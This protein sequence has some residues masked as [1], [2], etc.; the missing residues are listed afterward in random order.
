MP[1]NFRVGLSDVLPAVLAQVE[2]RMWNCSVISLAM[3]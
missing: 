1:S 2:I 3:E